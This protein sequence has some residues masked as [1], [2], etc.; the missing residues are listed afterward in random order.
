L[1]EFWNDWMRGLSIVPSNKNRPGEVVC[2]KNPIAEFIRIV[3]GHPN[4]IVVM[5]RANK[6]RQIHES[7]S[8]P[9]QENLGS[10]LPSSNYQQG[11]GD[12][13]HRP[14]Q[15]EKSHGERSYRSY[16][17]RSYAPQSYNSQNSGDQSLNNHSVAPMRFDHSKV[18]H[19]SSSRPC[20]KPDIDTFPQKELV[21]SEML[22]DDIETNERRELIENYV[23][24]KDEVEERGVGLFSKIENSRPME[25]EI[26]WCDGMSWNHMTHLQRIRRLIPRLQ[27]EKGDDSYYR[28]VLPTVK[29]PPS[30]R[31]I[32]KMRVAVQAAKEAVSRLYRKL[33]QDIQ[34]DSESSSGDGWS[35]SDDNRAPCILGITEEDAHT[36]IEN[37]PNHLLFTA[38]FDVDGTDTSQSKLCLCPCSTKKSREWQNVFRLSDLA[39][40]DACHKT[41]EH[42]ALLSHLEIK[43]E[44]DPLH[45]GTRAYLLSLYS[46]HYGIGNNGFGLDHEALYQNKRNMNHLYKEVMAFKHRVREK[47]VSKILFSYCII[48]IFDSSLACL[49]L[50]I[51]FIQ[52]T[53]GSQKRDKKL[54]RET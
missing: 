41:F 37:L 51:I 27:P 30:D 20:E 9:Y 26:N 47:S 34:S 50:T 46:N 15:R 21:K 35:S 8:P 11:Q 49:S 13:H 38:S 44:V 24:I 25:R 31:R 19:D 14:S 33:S 7:T 4:S 22:V 23:E 3:S 45:L 17:K 40:T 28:A 54:A 29:K 2:C 39:S 43:G 12:K 16:E 53:C 18:Q 10:E 6:K 42:F 5:T 48:L 1:R 36:F 32:T 52:S